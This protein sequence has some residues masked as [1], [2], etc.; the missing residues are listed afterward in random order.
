MDKER[1]P[2]DIIQDFIDLLQE[3]QKKYDD[4]MKEC[5]KMDSFERSKKWAHKFEFAPNKNER[6]KLATAY[7]NERKRRRQYKD[8]M[9]LHKAIH[10]FA[11]SENNKSTLKRLGGMLATQKH[12]EQYLDSNREY[13]AG[14]DSENSSR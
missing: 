3:S 11:N 8:I 9:D 13:K 6:N 2:S 12:Q 7:Q 14:D 10:D 4:A 1:K 5:E